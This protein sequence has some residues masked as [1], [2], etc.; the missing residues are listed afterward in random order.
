MGGIEGQ[1]EVFDKK[2]DKKRKRKRKQESDDSGLTMGRT[3]L[4]ETVSGHNEDFGKKIEKKRKKR[5]KKESNDSGLTMGETEFLDTVTEQNEVL[6]KKSEKKGKKRGKKESSDDSGFKIEDLL[7]MAS[8]H[9]EDIGKKAEKKREK[10]GKKKSDDSGLTMGGTDLLEKGSGH[11][12]DFGKKAD[13]KREK[14]RKKESDDSGLTMGETDFFEKASGHN[15][16]I[17]KKAEKKRKKRGKKESDDSS[18]FTMQQDLSTEHSREE[19]ERKKETKRKKKYQDDS[20]NA[21]EEYVEDGKINVVDNSCN[22]RRYNEAD[23]AEKENKGKM[24]KKKSKSMK[25]GFDE[26]W[27]DK[28]STNKG[29]NQIGRLEENDSHDMQDGCI[30]SAMKGSKK[31][32]KFVENGS[33]DQLPDNSNKKVRFTAQDEVFPVPS[34]LNT[35]KE[36]D[37]KDKM[38][39]GKRF[40]RE[41]D[42]IVKEAVRKYIEEH[43][44]GEE[45]LDMVLNCKKHRRQV[46]GCWKEIGSAIPY[47]PYVA[48]YYRAQILFRRSENRKWTQEEYDEILKYQKKHGNRWKEIA[49]E[50][51][52]HRF[53]VKDTWR[54]IKLANQ[55]KG[56]WTQGEYQKLFDLVNLDLQLKVF[57]EKK[58]KYGMLRDNIPWTA[59]SDKLTTRSQ[60]N[61]CLKWY[62]QLSSPMV[63]EGLWAD[64]DDYRLLDALYSYDATC[65]E[66]VDWDNILD[67]RSGDVCRKRWNQMVLHIGQHGSKSFS[68][69]VE[70]L[71]QRYCPH[72]IEARETWD[73]KPRIP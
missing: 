48:V 32:N 71:A 43:D 37:D 3:D 72:L 68:E 55:N 61:C 39:L 63:S 6:D 31:R 17:G 23:H 50:L 41:E 44:L 2:T 29:N 46:N 24:K 65:M 47:R 57:D 70:V 27:D 16:D 25:Y 21:L 22:K 10:R 14:V 18:L 49:E 5:G 52:K 58:S 9:D 11:N 38:V 53:H 15:A 64:V 45:G 51:G 30:K 19:C 12:E 35:E 56:H 33:S 26:I 4:L 60:A 40:T 7:E 59:I 36:N 28:L 66:D 42:E 67:N 1:N 13:K 20:S 8:G 69:Q 54:R 73:S 62:N 34:D